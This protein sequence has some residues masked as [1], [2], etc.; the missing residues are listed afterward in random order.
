MQSKPS[1]VWWIIGKRDDKEKDSDSASVDSTSSV[2]KDL[3][4]APGLATKPTPKRAMSWDFSSLKK[5]P[6]PRR[7][8]TMSEIDTMSTLSASPTLVNNSEKSTACPT[9]DPSPAGTP[10]QSKWLYYVRVRTN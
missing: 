7:S 1:G 9:P 6:T 10:G 2:Q 5:F 4:P 8:S 3:P